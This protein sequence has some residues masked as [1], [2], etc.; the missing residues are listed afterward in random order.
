MVSSTPTRFSCG[1]YCDSIVHE[2]KPIDDD[3]NFFLF[4][5]LQKGYHN[6]GVKVLKCSSYRYYAHELRALV[7][8]THYVYMLRNNDHS[9]AWRTPQT[10]HTLSFAN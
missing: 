4:T 7:F 5:G 3:F 2:L 8:K 1:I 10:W 6:G 9:C